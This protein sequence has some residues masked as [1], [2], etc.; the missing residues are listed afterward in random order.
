ML[1]V[2]VL[3]LLLNC[4][5]ASSLPRLATSVIGGFKHFVQDG[6]PSAIFF[7]R[8]SNYIRLNG[9]QGPTGPT[10]P[11]Y[12][13]TFS[14]HFFNRSMY[15]DALLSMAALGYNYVR[16][17]VDGGSGFRTDGINGD[18][19]SPLSDEYVQN[20]ADF[21][22]MAASVNIYTMITLESLPQNKYF[23]SLTG[24]PPSWAGFPQYN[25]FVPSF[26]IAWEEFSRL[27]MRALLARMSPSDTA[28]IF[29]ISLANELC[30]D[31]SQAPFNA[32]QGSIT[33]AD[34]VTYDMNSTSSRQQCM[35]ANIVHWANAVA[36]TIRT[37]SPY[38]FVTI[39]MFTF[40]AVGKSGPDGILPSA[41]PRH[42][43]RPAVLSQYSSLDFLDVHVYPTVGLNGSTW[44]LAS[45]L[46]SDEWPLVNRTRTPILMG[47]TG[48][49]KYFFKSAIDAAVRLVA[50]QI[51]SCNYQMVGWAVWTWDTWEQSGFLW[52]MVDGNMVVARDL[53]PTTRHNP[54]SFHATIF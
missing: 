45:D 25:F 13:S 4:N 46:A 31:A 5:S 21:V 49:F 7:P 1:W 43:V 44:T 22:T 54:C 14:P 17:F 30:A 39:G 12:H 48:A 18:G 34:G 23:A 10:L 2:V 33:T 47:E 16:V 42:P 19:S 20:L 40:Q 8:G 24:S 26:V 27:L 52:T 15:R 6:S 53:S 28:S 9:S 29:A 37:V 38:T 41:D 35:D 51:E 50:L 32:R 3:G 11:V 36:D